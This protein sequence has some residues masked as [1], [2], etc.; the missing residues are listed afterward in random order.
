MLRLWAD[1]SAASLLAA[2]LLGTIV[3]TTTG[4]YIAMGLAIYGGNTEPM[5][6]SVGFPWVVFATALLLG[7]AGRIQVSRATEN[8]ARRL[9]SGLVLA[10]VIA[11]AVLP[12]VHIARLVRATRT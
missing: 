2:G 11:V 3:A 7:L 4:P 6:P 8:R 9:W 12:L 5:E 10:A 1:T